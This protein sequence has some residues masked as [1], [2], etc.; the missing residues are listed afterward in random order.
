MQQ[1]RIFLINSSP[2]QSDKTNENNLQ[3]CDFDRQYLSEKA[4]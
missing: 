3:K 4:K 2:L 1:F